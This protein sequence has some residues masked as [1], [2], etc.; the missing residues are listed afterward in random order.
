MLFELALRWD[1]TLLDI[2]TVLSVLLDY[3]DC[4]A[5][6]KVVEGGTKLVLGC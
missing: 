4:K 6:T 1:L 3:H 2:D 5:L